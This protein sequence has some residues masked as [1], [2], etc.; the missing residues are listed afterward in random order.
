[1]F[2]QL[3][4]DK[5][6]KY[7]KLLIFQIDYESVE[8]PAWTCSALKDWIGST[9]HYSQL[10]VEKSIGDYEM[11]MKIWPSPSPLLAHNH[12]C[13]REQA[14]PHSL[15]KS[16]TDMAYII[17]LTL[18]PKE[19]SQSSPE[20]E[21]LTGENNKTK[22][23]QETKKKINTEK[24]CTGQMS[25]KQKQESSRIHRSE[26]PQYF[27]PCLA[28]DGGHWPD[29]GLGGAL[30]WPFVSFLVFFLMSEGMYTSEKLVCYEWLISHW[31]HKYLAQKES[32]R[33]TSNL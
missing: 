5:I 14:A 11:Q 19:M 2:H 32:L 10:L 20:K 25:E 29:T 4:R 26:S 33:L 7:L 22:W 3:E 1:M 30:A 15:S 24:R 8:Q 13:C 18:S 6:C 27:P 17:K 28:H 21:D 23:C 31:H 16:P 9:K 12:E